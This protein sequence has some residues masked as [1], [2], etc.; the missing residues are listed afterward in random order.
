[1]LVFDQNVD[2]RLLVH[3]RS[4]F[5][6]FVGGC[7]GERRG[8]GSRSSPTIL[9]DV[10]VVVA[11]PPRYIAGYYGDATM[12]AVIAIWLGIGDVTPVYAAAAARTKSGIEW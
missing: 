1:M 4:P 6:P 2:S 10:V 5:T 7:I 8:S 12:N 11:T 3:P 9:V